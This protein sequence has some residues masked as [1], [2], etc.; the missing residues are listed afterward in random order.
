[1]GVCW[2]RLSVR[3]R[4]RVRA[5][6]GVC[7]LRLRVRVRGRVRVRLG[8]CWLR[9]SVRMGR[10]GSQRGYHWSADTMLSRTCPSGQGPGERGSGPGL[11]SSFRLGRRFRLIMQ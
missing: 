3:V 10:N 5:R 4:V 8:V 1:M 6:L 7:W 2:L 9:L 11:A